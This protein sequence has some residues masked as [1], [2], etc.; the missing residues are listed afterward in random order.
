LVIRAPFHIEH[1]VLPFVANGKITVPI[2][3]THPL[4]DAAIA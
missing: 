1:E 4:D 3:A 2:A